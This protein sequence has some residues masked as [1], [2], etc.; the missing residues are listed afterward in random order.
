[1]AEFASKPFA[2]KADAAD[3]LRVRSKQMTSVVATELYSLIINYVIMITQS[4]P[5]GSSWITS[6]PTSASAPRTATVAARRA[7]Y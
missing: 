3:A 6:T 7:V 1:M 4:R 5:A 2:L